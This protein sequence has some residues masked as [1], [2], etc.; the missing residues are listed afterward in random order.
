MLLNS[1]LYISLS[2]SQSLNS[3]RTNGAS[4]SETEL[5]KQNSLRPELCRVCLQTSAAAGHQLLDY[6]CHSRGLV[7]G[8]K[9]EHLL[10]HQH[11]LKSPAPLDQDPP[12]LLHSHGKLT[13]GEDQW[14]RW[15]GGMWVRRT[16]DP[17]VRLH[18]ETWPHNPETN[19]ARIVTLYLNTRTEF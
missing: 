8:L 2:R 12:H 4:V 14:L 3:A 11:Q 10:H 13:W 6:D 17:V 7:Q 9:W 1:A 19:D 15:T 18:Q 16:W 5:D